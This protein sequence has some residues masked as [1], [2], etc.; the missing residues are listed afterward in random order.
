MCTIM[1]NFDQIQELWVGQ[2]DTNTPVQA[3]D[4]IQK[5]EKHLKKI[6]RGHIWTVT[7]LVVVVTVLVAYFAWLSLSRWSLFTTGLSLMIGMLVWRISLELISVR[8]FSKI[9]PDDSFLEY[10]DKIATF[11]TWRKKIHLVQTPIIYLSYIAGF[12]MLFPGF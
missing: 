8:R 10:S 3:A 9:K 11:Y 2:S 4:I 1:N 5:T 6:K 7:I 12:L